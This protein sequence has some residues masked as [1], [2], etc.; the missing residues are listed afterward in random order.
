MALADAG[1][2]LDDANFDELVANSAILRLY[3]F[4]KWIS[5]ELRKNVPAEGLDFALAKEGLD[6]WD[7][8][9][10]NELNR[11]IELTTQSYSEMKF[12]QAL[13]HGFFELQTLKE[14]YLIA[15]G[16]KANPFLLLKFIETQLVLMNPIVPHFAEFS[17]RTHVL[18]ILERSQNLQRAPAKQLINQGWPQAS[19]TFD[20]LSHRVYE[21]MKA[22]KSNVRL[23]YDRAKHGGKKGAK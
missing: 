1:D 5:E 21:Y 14:D 3:V 23:S 18:P 8:I 22:L 6:Q 13:K 11:A 15:K 2:G 16:G 10:E 12:K 9:L 17:W 20:T 7:L 4:E 19:K